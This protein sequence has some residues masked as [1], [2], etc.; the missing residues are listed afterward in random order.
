MAERRG[1]TIEEDDTVLELDRSLRTRLERTPRWRLRAYGRRWR[2]VRGLWENNDALKPPP[3]SNAQIVGG[4]GLVVAGVLA[5]VVPIGLGIHDAYTLDNLEEGVV[6]H[7]VR[8]YVPA[9]QH[10]QHADPDWLCNRLSGEDG[11]TYLA[12]DEPGWRVSKVRTD[13]RG[14]LHVKCRYGVSPGASH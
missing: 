5:V 13:S 9:W 4:A 2:A 11:P 1:F 10:D 12:P 6:Q 14:A 8:Y 7:G 3:R